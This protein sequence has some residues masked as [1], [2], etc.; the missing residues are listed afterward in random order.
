MK[1]MAASNSVVFQNKKTLPHY[2]LSYNYLIIVV[3]GNDD[4][5]LARED[6][7]ARCESN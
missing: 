6:D 2:Q 1:I 3:I 7:D 4:M 5:E